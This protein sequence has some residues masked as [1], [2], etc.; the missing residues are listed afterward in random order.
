MPP[1]LFVLAVAVVS[2][3]LTRLGVL[4]T[5]EVVLMLISMPNVR[6]LKICDCIGLGVDYF[7]GVLIF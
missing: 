1:A 3:E 7:R 6:E 4:T 2:V 5:E